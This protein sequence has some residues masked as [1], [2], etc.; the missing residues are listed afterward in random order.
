MSETNDIRSVT[1][2]IEIRDDAR[3]LYRGV[4]A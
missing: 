4:S 1:N 3:P 2:N